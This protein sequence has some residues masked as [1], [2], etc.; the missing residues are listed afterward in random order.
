MG[1]KAESLYYMYKKSLPVP[2]TLIIGKEAFEGFSKEALAEFHDHD[3][4]LDDINSI[5]EYS[6]KLN[7]S[8]IHKK[9]ESTLFDPIYKN[10]IQT[11]K[12]PGL[13][14]RSSAIGEDSLENS[15][16]GQLDSIV[17]DK[18]KDFKISCHD[19]LL[20]CWISYWKSRSL[21]YQVNRDTL[22]GGM[23]VVVQP[24][25]QSEISGVLF[26]SHPLIKNKYDRD[27]VFL[28][29]CVSGA[30]EQLVSGKEN[31]EQFLVSGEG[32]DLKITPCL[33]AGNQNKFLSPWISNIK[34]LVKIAKYIKHETGINQDIE[35]T[36][37]KS[38]R[39]W[40]LQSR[41]VTVKSPDQN[42][43]YVWSNVNVNENFP[44]ALTPFL[45]S[46]AKKGYYHYFKNLSE[47]FGVSNKFL[48]KLQPAFESIIDFHQSRMY[49]N[50]TN[51]YQCLSAFPLPELARKYWDSFIGIYD[52]QRDNLS[53]RLLP[54]SRFSRG[55]YLLKVAFLSLIHVLFLPYYVRRFE[56]QADYHVKKC[57]STER[58][59]S[60]QRYKEDIRG[61]INIRMYRWKDASLADTLAMFAYGFLQSSVK[62]Y[63]L[64]LSN[65]INQLLIGISDLASHES[66]QELWELT[67]MI[68]VDHTLND[69]IENNV[70][71][72]IMPVINEAEEYKSFYKAFCEYQN[73]W[74][75]RISG[76][77][78]LTRAD[79]TEAPEKLLELIRVY[80][81]NSSRESPQMQLKIQGK[82][83]LEVRKRIL[84]QV[85]K[86]STLILALFR[87]AIICTSIYLAHQGIKY[88][89]RVRLKQARLYNQCRHS[90]LKLG[91]LLK[92]RHYLETAED[93]I[94]LKYSEIKNLSEYNL[95]LLVKTVI[96]QRKNRY[97]EDMTIISPES[98]CLPEG[99]YY[100]FEK[101]K[102]P[103]TD[104]VPDLKESILVGYSAC[105]GKVTG[106]VKILNDISAIGMIRK[107]DILVTRQTDPGW[108]PAFPIISGLIL[109]RGGMLSHGAIIAREYGI[110][111]LVGVKDATT[112]LKNGQHVL[113]DADRSAVF[114]E[115]AI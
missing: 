87:K 88:R 27:N 74:G 112:R 45:M 8:L 1:G 100:S 73:K 50:L 41:P 18:S 86:D 24:Y 114:A 54:K 72:E 33:S 77:L 79:Y 51:I 42:K 19:A 70:W 105:E 106:R 111:T 66:Q 75:Y 110:P 46:F 63:A 47:L 82:K 55:I 65:N 78:L 43:L 98:F 29:E 80:L 9:I 11:F 20:E 35:W 83:R 62:K 93:I 26:T 14:F 85:G 3:I 44:E 94:F 32:S 17:T 56:K 108:A 34:N 68:K 99:V 61:F 39:L 52:L 95:A 48:K 57:N 23:A 91:S 97:K 58:E 96:K 81:K 37:D 113:L 59:H 109:E 102:I 71:E 2:E 90:L 25:I 76:E 30:N 92:E 103:K 7:E 13:I 115:D 53:D 6:K 4:E 28:I 5:N 21:S 107:G 31:P 12:T 64:S 104:N 67:Q 60:I 101:Q 22:L 36:V 69:L 10:I 40:I 84:K 38:K 89:E 15:F 16:A 49:Y